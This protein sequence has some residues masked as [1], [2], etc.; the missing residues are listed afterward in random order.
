MHWEDHLLNTSCIIRFWSSLY[1]S[2]NRIEFPTNFFNHWTQL[3]TMVEKS[4]EALSHYENQSLFWCLFCLHKS[5]KQLKWDKYCW[6]NSNAPLERHKH[7]IFRFPY[8]TII[9]LDLRY[10]TS[11]M[12]QAYHV[13]LSPLSIQVKSKSRHML[14]WTM[15]LDL[16]TCLFRHW[17]RQIQFRSVQLQVQ[18]L[19]KAL[20]LNTPFKCHS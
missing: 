16:K 7:S 17:V 12:L 9:W 8:K 19:W 5:T 4:L 6:S 15:D 18:K 11:F 2:R 1:K 14:F 10:F 13:Q 3:I 20:S